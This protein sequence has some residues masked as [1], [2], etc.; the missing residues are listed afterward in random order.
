MKN[1]IF[2][3]FDLLFNIKNENY[4]EENISDKDSDDSGDENNE[5]SKK[6]DINIL[7]FKDNETVKL[8]KD[9]LISLA[10][11]YYIKNHNDN[12]FNDLE[13]HLISGKRKSL[14]FKN[15]YIEKINKI[16]NQNKENKI[17]DSNK[18]N[19]KKKKKNHNNNN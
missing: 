1:L 9:K 13:I 4:L 15:I 7:N 18:F 12:D 3:L 11:Q 6:P 19:I 8:Y 17:D 14:A 5:I 10:D 16:L 2:K